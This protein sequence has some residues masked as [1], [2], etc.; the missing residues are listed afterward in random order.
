MR[1]ENEKKKSKT[2][3]LK[4]SVASATKKVKDE[5]KDEGEQKLGEE[6]RGE[7]VDVRKEEER[8]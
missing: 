5:E 3:D 6:R 1:T 8:R 2:N 4:M 7:E